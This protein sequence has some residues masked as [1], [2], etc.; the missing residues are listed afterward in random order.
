V[1]TIRRLIYV[2]VFSS[3]AFVTLGFLAL[4]TFFDFVDQL[5]SIGRPGAN[6]G[7]QLPQAAS[8]VALLIP[9]HLYELLPITVLIGT[10]FVMTRLA[11]SSEFTILRTSGLGPWRA[12]RTLLVTGLTFVVLTFAIGDYIAP[13]ADRTAQLLKA[14]FEG[15][16][17]VGQTGAWLRERQAYAQFAVNVGALAPDGSMHGVRI[18]EFDNKNLLV[19]LT[20]AQ[21]ARF[22]RDDSWR[23]EQ[24]ERTEFGSK[25]AQDVYVSRTQIPSFRW[26]TE[27][28]AEMV[29]AA[30]LRP[31]RMGTFDLFEYIRHLNA[32]GQ[33]AERYEIE[34][35]KKVFYP[36]SCLVMV[37]L[38]L[39]FAYLHFRN[40]G[41][42]VYVFGGVMAG[43][44]FFFLNNVFGY[45]G[46]LQ[47]WLPWLTAALP[48]M[49]YSLISLTAFGW[50]VFR[51]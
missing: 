46:E 38:A 37:V 7:Y 28:T 10:I 36:L 6:T 24:A 47:H 15:A 43:I 40:E 23:L 41:I 42:S 34:F 19:S 16:I 12:L 29:S 8:Y 11:Q 30:V 3:V 50:L 49:I 27:I 1:K 14:R 21:T 33:S 25:G 26:P 45:I 17:T 32:N 44:S 2:E 20:R 31:D 9:N 5:P 35:W 4:F 13:W 39:P 18:F 51:R 22:A 48:G